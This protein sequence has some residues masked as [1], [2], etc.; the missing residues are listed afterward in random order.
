MRQNWSAILCAV[1]LSMALS[2]VS[3]QSGV[4]AEDSSVLR[5]PVPVQLAASRTKSSLQT[6]RALNAKRIRTLQKAGITSLAKLS[7]VKA[8]RLADILKVDKNVAGSILSDA[9]KQLKQLQRVYRDNRSRVGGGGG[10]GSSYASLIAPTNECTILVRKVCG[11]ENQCGN[12]SGC[13]AAM[14][15]LQAYNSGNDQAAVA[16]ACVISLAD[17]IIFPWCNQ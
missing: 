5:T 10:G 1:V 16:E 2:V 14:N 3:G 12:G 9:S 6:V 15:L 4:R 8:G 11:Q 7:R 17:E 13:G